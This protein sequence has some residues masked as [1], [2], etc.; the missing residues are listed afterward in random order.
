MKPGQQEQQERYPQTAYGSYQDRGQEAQQQHLDDMRRIDQESRRTAL[1]L[2]PLMMALFLSVGFFVVAL[3][4]RMWSVWLVCGAGFVAF[5]G[6]LAM[7]LWP[8]VRR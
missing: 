8:P 5:A 1:W 3:D 7:A 2:W 6:I 4:G